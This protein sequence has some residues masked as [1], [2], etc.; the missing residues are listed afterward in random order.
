MGKDRLVF[1]MCL[2]GTGIGSPCTLSV[3]FTVSSSVF[4][5]IHENG[6]CHC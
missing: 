3:I 6:P 5:E 2:N 4:N 1:V